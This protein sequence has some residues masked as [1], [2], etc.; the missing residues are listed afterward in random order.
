MNSTPRE[1]T[2]ET[3]AAAAIVAVLIVVISSERFSWT[4]SRAAGLLPH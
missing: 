1:K 2:A 3:A 4:A